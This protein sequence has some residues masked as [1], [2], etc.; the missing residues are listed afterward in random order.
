MKI[1]H[2]H[3]YTMQYKSQMQAPL[4]H[5]HPG[6]S[7][8]IQGDGEVQPDVDDGQ[9]VQEEEGGHQYERLYHHGAVR[10]GEPGQKHDF[11][12]QH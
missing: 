1:S 12:Y 3:N 9:K 8:L 5:L 11:V 10:V 6:L 4:L 2:S 7:S